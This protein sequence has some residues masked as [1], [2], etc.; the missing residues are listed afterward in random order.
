MAPTV[1]TT[2]T[3]ISTALA[4]GTGE[5]SLFSTRLQQ[6]CALCCALHGRYAPSVIIPSP[7]LPSRQWT[8]KNSGTAPWLSFGCGEPNV[9]PYCADHVDTYQADLHLDTGCNDDATSCCFNG[10]RYDVDVFNKLSTQYTT[11][12]TFEGLIKLASAEV[13]HVLVE[14]LDAS[15][16]IIGTDEW[17]VQV[18]SLP[19]SPPLPPDP[20][21]PLAPGNPP[22]LPPPMPM[23][24]ETPALECQGK[25][26]QC[27]ADSDCC[28]GICRAN[29]KRT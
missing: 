8:H 4:C 24:P 20:P 25:N 5:R 2:S 18:S 13:V 16:N 21:A 17:V 19:P 29:S 27:S 11:L 10:V 3:P 6:T 7:F 14:A 26:G 15:G 12:L 1:H 9:C 23:T 28:S 22:G